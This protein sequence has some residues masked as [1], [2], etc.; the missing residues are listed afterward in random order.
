MI[1][2]LIELGADPN[3][4]DAG[5]LTPLVAAAMRDHVASVKVLLE[6]GADVEKPGQEGYHPLALSIAEAKYESAKAMIDGG[7]DVSAA[8]GADGLT[9][10]MLTAAQTA[11]AEGARFV[12]G[13]T[14]PTDLAKALI[15]RGAEVNAQAKNGMTALMIAATHNSAPMIGLLMDAG[16]DPA[17]KNKQGLTATD[18]AEKNGNLQAA[19]AIAVLGSGRSASV[20]P[21][22]S[23]GTE[24]TTSQ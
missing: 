11:P 23:N 2:T 10:L 4:A 17:L 12:P 7:A 9:P 18:V 1:K 16:A 24:A 6:N 13:S 15:E 21:P 22:N 19:Q 20:P 3:L 5:G 14:H 8:S